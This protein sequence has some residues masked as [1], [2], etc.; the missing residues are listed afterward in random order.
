MKLRKKNKKIQKV[1]LFANP[2]FG[3]ATCCNWNAGC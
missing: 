3:C 2:E 1:K